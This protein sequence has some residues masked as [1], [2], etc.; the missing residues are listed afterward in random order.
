MMTTSV[1]GA[2]GEPAF[3]G[4]TLDEMKEA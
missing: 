2:N 4:T 1:L 3:I